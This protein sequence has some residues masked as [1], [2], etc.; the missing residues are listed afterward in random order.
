MLQYYYGSSMTEY[1]APT[2]LYSASLYFIISKTG[3]LND[4]RC[5]NQNNDTQFNGFNCDTKHE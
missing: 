2:S 5:D 3:Q 1:L 4:G